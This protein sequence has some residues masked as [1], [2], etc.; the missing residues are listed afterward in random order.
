[1]N[2]GRPLPVVQS[3]RTVIQRLMNLVMPLDDPSPAGKAKFALTLAT[4]RPAIDTALNNVG[5][6]HFARFNISGPFLHM[7]SVYD[8]GAHSYIREIALQ[9]GDVFDVIMDH[10][11][12]WPPPTVETGDDLRAESAARP[13]ELRRNSIAE[14]PDLFVEWVMAHDIYQLPRDAVEIMQDNEVGYIPP[15]LDDE[16]FA[17]LARVFTDNEHVHLSAYRGYAGAT[18]PAIRD[19]LR[20]GW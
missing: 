6:L 7:I 12:D 15:R 19:G 5:T 1:M 2:G 8:G 20:M 16:L 4:H 13:G 9:L 3:P 11:A 10:I 14:N 18:V 17:R